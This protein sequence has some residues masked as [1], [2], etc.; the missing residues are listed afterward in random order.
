MCFHRDNPSA[1]GDDGAGERSQAGADVNDE[2]A[3]GYRRLSDE[4][5][6]PSG[7]ELVPRPAPL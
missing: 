1:T 4:P 6:R 7:V 2:G 5:V 3:W